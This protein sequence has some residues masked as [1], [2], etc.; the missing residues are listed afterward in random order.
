MQS[1]RS[2]V[3][4]IGQPKSGTTALQAAARDR[5]D[6]LLQAGVVY[7]G[8]RINHGR[9]TSA[10]MGRRNALW[11]SVPPMAEWDALLAEVESAPGALISYEQVVEADAAAVQR[12]ADA[13]GERMHVLL[14]LRPLAAT[15]GSI[16]QQY[17]KTSYR[18]TLADWTRAVLPPRASDVT[19]TFWPRHD[20]VGQLDRWLAIVPPDRFTIVIVDAA[21]PQRTSSTVESLLELPAG[22]LAPSSDRMRA[23]RALSALEIE[24]VRLLNARVAALPR[25]L[26]HRFVTNG[27]VAALLRTRTP[28]IDEGR[29][30]V[31]A[32]AVAI[33]DA[34]A[35]DA[36]GRIA[37]SGVHVVGDPATLVTGGVRPAVPIIADE[38]RIAEVARV[39]LEGVLSQRRDGAARKGAAPLAAVPHT[40]AAAVDAVAA[41]VLAAADQV[42]GGS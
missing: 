29:D 23:N 24:F 27:V 41:E 35:A 2:R 9:E 10:L 26:H 19:P 25:S 11:P 16:W 37:A 38:G 13:L 17:V 39:A 34:L 33:A 40:L 28:G 32:D 7:P 20:T 21:H 31:G 3:L 36:V 14:T 4:H 22:L 15:L 42:A 18:G 1:A 30:A 5:R 6:A 12:F 8:A